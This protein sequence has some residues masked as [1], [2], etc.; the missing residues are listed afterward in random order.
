MTYTT[1]DIQDTLRHYGIDRTDAEVEYA[2]DAVVPGWALENLGR[3]ATPDELYGHAE[4]WWMVQ[5]EIGGIFDVLEVN[6]EDENNLYDSR[7]GN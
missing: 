1:D 6:S 3:G 5:Y 4:W 7:E 2:V